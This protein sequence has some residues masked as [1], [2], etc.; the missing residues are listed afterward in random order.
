L[1]DDINYLNAEK[2]NVQLIVNGNNTS[3]LHNP[4]LLSGEKEQQML[5]M[6]DRNKDKLTVPRRPQ[7]NTSTT[8]E[9]L[10]SLEKESFLEWRRRLAVLEEDMQ[11]VVTPFERNIEVWRQ[12]WRVL[13]RSDVVVQIVDARNP[14]F[15]YS[16]DLDKYIREIDVNKHRLLLINKADFLT[17]SQRLAGILIAQYNARM[18]FYRVENHG[19]IISVVVGFAV[20]SFRLQRR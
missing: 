20:P 1:I 4:Y 18:S 16:E 17:E 8:A 19:L 11:M 7:W 12:L 6:M 5:D 3:A 14:L 9:E 10:H 2:L 15:F 13:E